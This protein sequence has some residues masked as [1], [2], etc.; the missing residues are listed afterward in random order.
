MCGCVTTTSRTRALSPSE[1]PMAMLP[2]SM[3][4][5]PSTTK[6]LK[7][8]SREAR[9]SALIVLGRSFIFTR[10]SDGV[11]IDRRRR[12]I[13][14][15]ASTKAQAPAIVSGL[16]SIV[17]SSL[18]LHLQAQALELP[19][20]VGLALGRGRVA[21]VDAARDA[22]AVEGELAARAVESLARPPQRE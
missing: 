22:R 13:K 9:P 11:T 8:C 17:P 5:R 20:V 15:E 7:R 12:T 14:A 10:L 18:P 2:A 21:R 6:Q 4:T 3:A 1:S 19:H 16:S